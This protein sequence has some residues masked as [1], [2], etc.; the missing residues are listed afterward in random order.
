MYSKKQDTIYLPRN[1]FIWFLLAFQ[2]GLLNIGGYLAVHR[3]VSHLTGFATLFGHEAVT[4]SWIAAF[5]MLLGPLFYLLG[6]MDSAWFIERNRLKNLRPQYSLVFIQMIIILL[7]I[8]VLGHLGIFGIFMEPF[9][10]EQDYILL[11]F[12]AF[13]CGLQNAVITSA[14]GAII[15]TT[16]LTGPTTDLGIGLVKLWTE[17]KKHNRELVIAT[18][19]RIGIIISFILG[20]FIGAFTFKAFKFLGFVVPVLI[21]SFVLFRL[22]P[23]DD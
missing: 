9:N 5:G 4:N 13:T 12:L 19:L 2:G 15:R 11:F 8:A 20:S 6:A 18:W 7:L 1:I 21:T 22:Q 23:E 10:Y 3:F 14:S 17:R 16:H